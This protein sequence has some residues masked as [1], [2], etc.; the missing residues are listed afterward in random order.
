MDLEHILDIAFAFRKSKALLTAVELR[1]FE[2]LAEGPQDAEVLTRRMGLQGRGAHDFLDTLVA[3]RLLDRDES[4]RYDNSPACAMHLDPRQPTYI[5]GLF[6]YLNDRMYLTWS[7]LT[8]ALREGKPQCGLAAVGGFEGLSADGVAL[9]TFLAGMTGG[10]RMVGRSLAE[11][12]PWHEYRTVVDIGTAQGCVPSEIALAHDH[13]VGGGFDLPDL[14]PAFERY[15]RDHGLSSRLVFHPGDFFA[16]PLP[17]ADVL[18]MGRVLH[19][20]DL[21]AR[22]LLLEKAHAALPPGGALI[23]HETF[24]DDARRVRSHSLLAS[25]NMLLQTDGGSEFTEVEC[26]TWMHQ[27][28]FCGTRIVSLAVGHSAVIAEK[29]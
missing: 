13:L 27:A 8:T 6:E 18:I 28:G 16:D 2:I 24:I 26:R 12:F 19:D 25:L 11:R 23:V 4:G 20:W 21:P 22:L 1:V 29:N 15:V 9:K 17:Q 7:H 5:G 14:R 10:S 3:L